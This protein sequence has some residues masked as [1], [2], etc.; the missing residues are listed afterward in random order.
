MNAETKKML[1]AGAITFAIVVVAIQ[2]NNRW[3]TPALDKA[4]KA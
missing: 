4:L 3:I 1:I 2:V